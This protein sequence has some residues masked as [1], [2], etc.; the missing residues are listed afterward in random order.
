MAKQR[1]VTRTDSW[2]NLYSGIGVTGRDRTASTQHYADLRL[3][4]QVLEGLYTSNG[5]ARRFVELIT[6]ELTREWFEIE[7]D[8]DDAIC[9]RLEEIGAKERIRDLIRWS[10]V[11]GGALG[12]LLIDDGQEF[13]QPIDEARI[14]S[15]EA[16]QVYERARVQVQQSDYYTDPTMP[17]FGEPQYYTVTPATMVRGPDGRF[18][19]GFRVHESR[20][21]RMDGLPVPPR[22][23]RMNQGWGDSVYQAAFNE[24]KNLGAAQAG[25]AN[26]IEDFVQAVIGIKGLSAKMAAGQ[27]AQVAARIN[28]IDM[29]R[30]VINSVVLDA[31]GES[32]S[33]HA[34][35]VSGL[36]ELITGFWEA[37]CGTWDVPMTRMLGRSPGGLNA[38]GES[39][40]R[41][42]YDK[43][44][45]E[46]EDKL[47]PVLERIVKLNFLAKSGP[48]NGREPED[49]GIEFNPLWQMS[50]EQQAEIYSKVS[51]ADSANVAA[52]ILDEDEIA[53]KRY[54]VPGGFG[55][56]EIDPDTRPEKP[57]EPEPMP[58]PQVPQQQAIPQNSNGSESTVQ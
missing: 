25:V 43:I 16:I 44:A 48:T 30:H 31:D 7:G 28:M 17:K 36:P 19:G 57:E 56:I 50:E 58:I 39:D 14:Q 11:Y 8:E 13:D 27:E 51:Q 22:I 49:W 5:I 18:I 24:L 21:V 6:N 23:R 20:T 10:M 41:G 2:A 46:Q 47:G 38:T 45:G 1:R 29:S 12:V 4:E 3:P 9:G 40:T 55:G 54:G 33:K 37:L 32:Y 26:I 15:F 34:S 35:S 42:F 53:R 52:G